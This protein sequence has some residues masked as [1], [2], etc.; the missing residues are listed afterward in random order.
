MTIEEG[1]ELGDATAV[2]VMEPCDPQT[3]SEASEDPALSNLTT[4]F[5][6]H[7]KTEGWRKRKLDESI[8]PCDT[9]G[10]QQRQELVNL[11]ATP[12]HLRPG[13]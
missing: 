4:V 12:Q 3:M 6:V 2:D 1:S 5:R 8:G 11:S 7:A 10:T 13:G 9:L